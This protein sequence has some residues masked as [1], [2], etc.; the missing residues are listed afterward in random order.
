MKKAHLLRPIHALEADVDRVRDFGAYA[1]R[2]LEIVELSHP[3]GEPAV[4]KAAGGRED[5]AARE[6]ECGR[7][8]ERKSERESDRARR[9]RAAH[10]MT[11]THRSTA[12]YTDSRRA[13]AA[14][15]LGGWSTR[16][17]THSSGSGTAAPRAKSLAN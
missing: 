17:G 14:G 8:S 13:S 16:G 11:P 12:L 1:R 7:A 4:A 6:F 10:A 9:Q 5:A 2:E 15:V 3:P